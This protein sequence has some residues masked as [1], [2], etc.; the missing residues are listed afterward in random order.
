MDRLQRQLEL[1]ILRYCLRYSSRKA[2][3][4]LGITAS[5]VDHHCRKAR[6]R[7]APVYHHHRGTTPEQ[8]EESQ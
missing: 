1:I 2:G 7:L 3:W 4:H 6:E 8:K 5:T